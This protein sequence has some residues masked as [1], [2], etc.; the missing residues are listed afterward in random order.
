M[1][2]FSQ[3]V[4]SLPRPIRLRFDSI[5]GYVQAIISEEQENVPG[6]QHLTTEEI[7]MV[8]LVVF[9][10][11]AN[12][13]FKEGSE[14]ARNAA[15]ELQR[16]TIPGFRVGSTHFEGRNRNVMLGDHLATYLI[17]SFDGS[18]FQNLIL[19]ATS[20]TDLVRNLARRIRHERRLG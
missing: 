3:I 2:S 4:N 7:E 14:A 5:G 18:P 10:Y 15:D 20:M 1:A 12:R 9:C 19:S 6:A 11:A 13:F 17:R 16:F 8:K